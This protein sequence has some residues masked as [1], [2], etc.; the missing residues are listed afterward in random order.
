VDNQPMQ[1][2]LEDEMLRT[3]LDG[4]IVSLR[5]VVAHNPQIEPVL[6][7]GMA[8]ETLRVLLG[9]SEPMCDC[10][11]GLVGGAIWRPGHV[12]QAAVGLPEGV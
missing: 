11:W 4:V 10:A 5:A 12:E 7:R 3:T 1:N 8:D 6:V 9:H 2:G